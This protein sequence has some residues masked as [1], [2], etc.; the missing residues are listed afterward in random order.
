MPGGCYGQKRPADAVGLAVVVGRIAMGEIEE[1]AYAA[2]SNQ[3]G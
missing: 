2:S 1:D 3:I